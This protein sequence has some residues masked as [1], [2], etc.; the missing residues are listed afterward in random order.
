MKKPKYR[1]ALIH[2]TTKKLYKLSETN[3]PVFFENFKQAENFIWRRLADTQ[4]Y[5]IIDIKKLGE[6]KCK[7]TN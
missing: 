3:K 1:F 7:N 6:R 2:K 4:A 5:D